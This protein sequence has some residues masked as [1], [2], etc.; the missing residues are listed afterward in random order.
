MQQTDRGTESK[1]GT[2]KG[3][4]ITLLSWIKQMHIYRDISELGHI[5]VSELQVST[6]TT[7]DIREKHC[8]IDGIM[9]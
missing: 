9:G 1:C 5:A 7:Y 3:K 6:Y 8:K 4:A 2:T